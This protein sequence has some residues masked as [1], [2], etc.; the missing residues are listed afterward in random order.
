MII[1]I[2]I[3][4]KIDGTAFTIKQVVDQKYKNLLTIS[5]SFDNDNS[6]QNETDLQTYDAIVLAKISDSNIMVLNIN[7]YN[8]E[9]LK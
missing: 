1:K 9:N 4:I 6:L 2:G 8:P 5:F 3:L 7:L